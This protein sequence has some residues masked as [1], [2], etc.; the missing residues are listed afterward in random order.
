MLI[1]LFIS[2]ALGVNPDGQLSIGDCDVPKLAEKYGTPLY[3]MDES[4]ISENMRAYK[5]VIDE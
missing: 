5:K 3:I 1:N 2:K 4:L